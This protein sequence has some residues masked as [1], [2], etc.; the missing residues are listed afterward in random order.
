MLFSE[1]ASRYRVTSCAARQAW[2]FRDMTF[3]GQFLRRSWY[4]LDTR[5]PGRWSILQ[6]CNFLSE[7]GQLVT[8]QLRSLAQVLNLFTQRVHFSTQPS[9]GIRDLYLYTLLAGQALYFLP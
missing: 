5:G 4:S 1:C 7:P 2:R 6:I 3:R 9:Q 8:V